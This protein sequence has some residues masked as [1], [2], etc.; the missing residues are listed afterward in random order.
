VKALLRRYR[1]ARDRWQFGPLTI[2]PKAYRVWV[3]GEEVAMTAKELELLI[4]LAGHPG[5]VFSREQ[6]YDR[7]WGDFGDPRTVTVHI[8]RIR[9]KIEPDPARPQFIQTVR[10]L[11]YRFAGVAR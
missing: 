4:F 11:G 5:Q 7:V 1:P 8:N 2:D 3:G 9:E 6:I 10:G